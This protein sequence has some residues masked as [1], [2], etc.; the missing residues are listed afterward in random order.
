MIS[1]LHSPIQFFHWALSHTNYTALFFFFSLLKPGHNKVF[2]LCFCLTKKP[3]LTFECETKDL[4]EIKDYQNNTY[5]VAWIKVIAIINE[6]TLNFYGLTKI[7]NNRVDMLNESL[8]RNETSHYNILLELRDDLGPSRLHY[9]LIPTLAQNHNH[10]VEM[11]RY[12][13]PE[14]NCEWKRLNNL[15]HASIWVLEF[16]TFPFSS[17]KKLKP[18]KGPR[19][20]IQFPHFMVMEN[21][22]EL[23]EKSVT[24]HKCTLIPCSMFCMCP[25]SIEEPDPADQHLHCMSMSCVRFFIRNEQKF[26]I[27]NDL[28]IIQ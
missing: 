10:Q 6:D 17:L 19:V 9:V 26:K 2:Y 3:N 16:K 18:P 4:C 23:E 8:L 11:A 5:Q 25:T 13:S 21:I 7:N 12:C 24:R 27:I 28:S 20:T 15:Q 22:V 14:P 1:T